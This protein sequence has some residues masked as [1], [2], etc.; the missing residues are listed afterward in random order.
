MQTIN[1]MQK[2][3]ITI[4]EY[5]GKTKNGIGFFI[6]ASKV[7][8]WCMVEGTG[9]IA[10]PNCYENAQKEAQDLIRRITGL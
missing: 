5:C 8:D 10:C 3:N 9:K 4:C 1:K 2:K 7:P 6:G